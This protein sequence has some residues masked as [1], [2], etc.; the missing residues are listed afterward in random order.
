MNKA[1]LPAL[2]NSLRSYPNLKL[3]AMTSIHVSLICLDLNE[4]PDE[5][6]NLYPKSVYKICFMLLSLSLSRL[7]LQRFPVFSTPGYGRGSARY[8]E[9]SPDFEFPGRH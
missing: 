7:Y 1:I 9:A 6:K 3:D 2:K 8:H 4:I 5:G